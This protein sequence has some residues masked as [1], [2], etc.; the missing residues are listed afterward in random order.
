MNAV[1]FVSNDGVKAME[2]AEFA[3]SLAV[4]SKMPDEQKRVEK[5]NA[6]RTARARSRR[7]VEAG[8]FDRLGEVLGRVKSTVKSIST[9]VVEAAKTWRDRRIDRPEQTPAVPT[10][11]DI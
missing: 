6:V 11:I 3:R 5:N 8:V 2:A 10:G 4:V 9:A 7:V 1:D